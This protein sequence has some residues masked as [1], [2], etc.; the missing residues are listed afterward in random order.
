VHDAAH[1]IDDYPH[2]FSGGMRQRVII[3]MAI[4]NEPELIIADEPTT[5]L[6]VT[7][8]A[9]VLDLLRSL[10]SELG[11]GMILVT[12]DMGVV[13]EVADSLLVMYAG[14]VAEYGPAERVL[15]APVHPYTRDL[16]RSTPSL[17]T[18][19]TSRLPTIDGR[20]PD[21]FDR[22]TGCPFHPRCHFAVDECRS[23]TPALQTAPDESSHRAAC[24]LMDRLPAHVA[25]RVAHS[26]PSET[27]TTSGEPILEVEDAVIGYGRAGGVFRRRAAKP[28]VKGVSLRAYPGRS[29]GLVGESGSGKSTLARAVVGLLPVWSGRVAVT[30]H[31]W[32]EADARQVAQLRRSV[33]MVFQ[34]SYLSLNPRQTISQLLAE[35]LHVH[36]LRPA[37][38]IQQRVAEL[39]DIVGLPDSV[40]D[41]RAY[42]LSGGQR[43]R[44][45]IARALAMEP[46]LIVADE[47][48]SALDVSV[49]AQIINL[50]AELRDKLSISYLFI[51][52]DL[53]V[54]RHLCEDVV[55]MERGRIV[56]AGPVDEVFAAPQHPYTVTLLAAAPGSNHVDQDERQA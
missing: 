30:G 50:L 27:P 18:P 29:L 16:M 41:R 56:E 37:S 19:R 46:Q 31:A 20:P 52:H 26:A 40:W 35:P 45:G 13:E 44:V 4:A 6:D 49:Q 17:A 38:K 34:D 3:A 22:P 8:Q 42:Q 15:R 14:R 54:V 24:W 9:E 32:N 51:S 43:Q 39:L 36:Q 23:A 33:Q 28:I 12:H 11:A 7:I 53:K 10:C 25:P 47:P 21:V 5:A 55:V 1:R 2:Q 48:V